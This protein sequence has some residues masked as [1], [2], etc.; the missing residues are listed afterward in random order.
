[1]NLRMAVVVTAQNQPGSDV[2]RKARQRPDAGGSGANCWYSTEPNYYN[3]Y[4][5]EIRLNCLT[6][7]SS[8]YMAEQGVITMTRLKKLKK[9]DIF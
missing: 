5:A 4:T 9:I 8:D 7:Y 2:L 6:T 1:M 3:P